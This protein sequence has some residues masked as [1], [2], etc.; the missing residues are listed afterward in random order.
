MRFLA[1]N[2]LNGTLDLAFGIE[3]CIIDSPETC[4]MYIDSYPSR[5]SMDDFMRHHDIYI[6]PLLHEPFN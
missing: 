2:T 4:R 6:V 1:P 3:A 5:D